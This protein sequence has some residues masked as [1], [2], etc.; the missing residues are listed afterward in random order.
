ME[1]WRKRNLFLKLISKLGLYQVVLTTPKTSPEKI[2]LTLVEMQQLLEIEKV[3]SRKEIS[4]LKKWTKYDGRRKVCISFKTDMDN[5]NIVVYRYRNNTYVKDSEMELKLTE[6]GKLSSER[7]YLLSYIDVFLSSALYWMK[8]LFI[9]K[10]NFIKNGC[11]F[12]HENFPIVP[13]I[14]N[15]I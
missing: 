15:I 12:P 13:G 10:V 14:K 9:I 7:V 5:L 1:H 2:T 8:Q 6:Y 4:C 11:S 3:D